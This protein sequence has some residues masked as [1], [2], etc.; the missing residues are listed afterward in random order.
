MA[1][2]NMP[3]SNSRDAPRFSSDPNAFE[4]FFED[5]KELVTR[6]GLQDADAIKWALRYASSESESWR[7]IACLAPGVDPAPTFDE[8]KEEVRKVYPHLSTTRRY[9][10]EDLERLIARTREYLD[11]TRDDFGEYYRRFITYTAYLLSNDRLSNRERN[12]Y[13]LRGFPQPIHTRILQRLTIKK[14]DVLPDEGYEFQDI[15][16]AASFI[17]NGG[18]RSLELRDIAPVAKREAADQGSISELVQAMTSLTQVFMSN[19]QGQQQRPPP[20][21][22]PRPQNE[23]PTPGGVIQN[24]PR[25]SQPQPQPQPQQGCMFCS[26]TDHFVRECP[27]AAQYLQQ[28]KA[29]RNEYGRISLPD[30]SYPPRNTPGRNMRE[31]LDN[32]WAAILGQDG[33]NSNVVSTNF[34]EGPDECVFTFDVSPHVNDEA[35]SRDPDPSPYDLDDTP[36]PLEEAQLI[37]AQIDSLREA[38]VLALQKGGKKQQF[39]GVEIVKRTGPPRKDGRLPPPP[40]PPP[41]QG[42]NV[43]ARVPPIPSQ[44]IPK[45]NQTSAPA[46]NVTGKQGTRAGDHPYQ[47]PQG[48]I[49]PVAMPPKPSTDD[50]KFRYQSPVEGDVKASDLTDRVLDAKVTISTRELL[51]VSPDVRRQVKDLVSSKKVSANTVEVDNTDAYL[52]TCFNSEVAAPPVYLDLV[53]Y[54]NASAAVSSLPLRVIFPSFAKGVEPECILDGGAQVVVMRKDIWECLRVPIV[55]NKAMDVESANAATTKTLGMVENH[56]VQ[57]GPITI[58]LQI[59]VVEKAPFE[60]LL[61]RPF[62]DITSCSEISSAGGHHEIHVKHPTTG[63]P[64]VFA[65]EPRHPRDIREISISEPAVN[66]RQ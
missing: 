38:Q 4:Y 1:H 47:R 12:A 33:A 46:P 5:V 31:R 53:K 8:F 3:M 42:P 64:Y 52:T 49:R 14:P 13:Y 28:G 21:R 24:V 63:A 25:W 54:E 57:L 41:P 59:Q 51:A 26:G 35:T 15:H 11:M 45:P 66:F 61:G 37:Q 19:V 2:V 32:Y 7:H 39:D 58:Y 60:V 34:L 29:I 20:P 22:F 55:A 27:V 9:T 48:P 17:L 18:D 44:S 62:F 40:P 30:G 23:G 16:D 50:Q 10:H 6:A 43:Y 65:T 36:S 56:P